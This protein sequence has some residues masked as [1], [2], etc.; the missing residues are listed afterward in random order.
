[1]KPEVVLGPRFLNLVPD[2][3]EHMNDLSVLRAA[4]CVFQ[5]S[6]RAKRAF[7]RPILPQVRVCRT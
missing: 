4:C 2:Y 6:V 7:A 1:M 5:P 3:Q